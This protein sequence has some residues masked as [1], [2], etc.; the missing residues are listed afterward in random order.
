M[1]IPCPI[2]PFVQGRA[3]KQARLAPLIVQPLAVIAEPIS[4]CAILTFIVRYVT[5]RRAFAIVMMNALGFWLLCF[6]DG[7]KCSYFRHGKFSFAGLYTRH[8]HYGP[9]LPAMNTTPE[10]LNQGT[11]LAHPFGDSA[12][13]ASL[14][15]SSGKRFDRAVC[16]TSHADKL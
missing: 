7:V 13:K 4:A 14:K 3:A 1:Q 9:H 5:T 2:R 12:E 16:S 10:H 15:F 11:S 8:M 6:V